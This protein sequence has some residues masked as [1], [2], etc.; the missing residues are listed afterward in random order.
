M[1]KI[2]Y[3]LVFNRKKR[4]NKK[5]MALVQV[6]AYLNRRKIYFST[7]IYL[8]PEQWD[9][10]RRMVK[11]HPN[12]DVLNR[13]LYEHIAAIEQIE[14][15]LW[16]QGKSISLELLKD[17]IDKPVSNGR[18]F[19]T[20]FREE[21]ANSSLKE[22]TRQNHLSTLELL[23]EFKKEVQ[24]TDLTFE[25]VSSF[26][27]YLQSKGYHLNTIAKHMKHLKRY[28][29]VAINK[30]YMDVQKYAFRKYKIKSVEGRHSHLSPEEL[31]KLEDLQ[32]GGKYAKLQKTKDSFLFCCYAG[33]RYSDFT[34]LTS[35]NI[36]EFQQ[37]TWLIYKSVKTGIEVRLPLYLLFEGK[38]IHILQRYK[39][40]LNR[41]FKLKDNSNINKELN[42]LGKLAEIDKRISFHSLNKNVTRSVMGVQLFGTSETFPPATMSVFSLI[43]KKKKQTDIID[44]ALENYDDIRNNIVKDIKTVYQDLETKAAARLDSLYQYQ[45]EMGREAL[46]QAQQL[47]MVY[48]NDEIRQTLVE[49]KQMLAEPQRILAESKL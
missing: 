28:V 10:K 49:A 11:G 12:A 29:N 22:S 27:N 25:F 35:A 7:K 43:L 8:K 15:G 44:I 9:T 4:L 24:F 46:N 23:Q 6:E 17:S 2:S 39:D 13:M 34:N 38:G 1:E 47:M 33:L 32:L 40:D 5:G 26:D 3:N 41:F 14:L 36:V 16:Q 19:L 37:E 21:V 18:S 31:H 20:F 45:V 42:I 30:D 48:D